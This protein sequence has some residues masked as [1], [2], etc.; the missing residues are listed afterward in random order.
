MT[1]E[2]FCTLPYALLPMSSEESLWEWDI[3][4]DSVFLSQG[5]LKCLALAAP[6]RKMS[7]YYQLLQPDAA[8]TLAKIREKVIS[9]RTGSSG[10]CDYICNG[11]KIHEFLLVLSRNSEGR[12]I[13]LMGTLSSTPIIAHETIFLRDSAKAADVGLWIYHPGTGTLWRNRTYGSILGY[14][15]GW[16]AEVQSSSPIIDVHP[17]DMDSLRRHYEL[18]CQSDFLGEQITDIIRV[19]KQNGE[20]LSVMA[21]ACAVERNNAGNII[22]MAGIVAANEPTAKSPV[23][24]SKGDLINHALRHMGNGQWAWDPAGDYMYLCDRFIEIL[25]YP[26]TDC[27]KMGEIWRDLIHPDDL[28]KV[29]AVRNAAI[30]GPENGDAFECTYRMK[31]ADGGWVWLF[32][33]GLV[34]W[35]DADGRAGHMIGSITNI[36]TAQAERDK[37]EELVRHDSLTGLRSRAFLN[38][39]MEHIERNSIRPVSIISVDITG[40]KMVNDSLGHARGDELLT[41][42]STLL[43][44]AL[45][46]SDCIARI[47]GDE[48]LALFPNCD[49]SQGRVLLAKIEEAFAEYNA[50][51]L[52]LPVYAAFGLATS[53][54]PDEPLERVMA[55]ADEAMYRYKKAARPA[56]RERIKSWIKTITGRDAAP[57]DRL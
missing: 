46:R 28:K 48:F 12:A 24:S 20:Y 7:D 57:E 45:R 18:F 50:H 9:G 38:L 35:R 10:E 34:T 1:D 17:S 2:T 44:T 15:D 23:E 26:H 36:T 33:R 47:G 53:D 22:T 21:R 5:A 13:R 37:L 49:Y 40:L 25:G 27:E 41:K 31:R 3:V 55:R 39:E 32:D 6:P 52:Q 54:D 30:S 29:E 8:T 43:R 4:S 14:E 11:L 16:D 42:A 51:S 19:R 56:V